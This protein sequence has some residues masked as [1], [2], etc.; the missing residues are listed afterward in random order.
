MT[1]KTEDLLK[2]MALKHMN[3]YFV[4]FPDLFFSFRKQ[5][6]IPYVM[7]CA[8]LWFRARHPGAPPLLVDIA[9]YR[10]SALDFLPRLSRNIPSS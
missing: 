4:N 1:L 10:E 9:D 7:S 3:F 2:T 6:P 8:N 5:L